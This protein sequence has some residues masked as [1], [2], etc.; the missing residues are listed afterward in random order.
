MEALTNIAVGYG[1][2]V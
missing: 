1:I 2:A